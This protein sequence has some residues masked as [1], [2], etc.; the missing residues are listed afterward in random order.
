MFLRILSRLLLGPIST[1]IG[2][3]NSSQTSPQP[4]SPTPKFLAQVDRIAKNLEQLACNTDISLKERLFETARLHF[5]LARTHQ[6]IHLRSQAEARALLTLKKLFLAEGVHEEGLKT[7]LQYSLQK[8]RPAI[9]KWF[10]ERAH[11]QCQGN[12]AL[13]LALAEWHFTCGQTAITQN[14]I[15]QLSLKSLSKSPRLARMWLLWNE[16]AA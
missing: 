1:W 7:L 9:A 14:L 13:I 3:S 11:L 8:K 2:S 5:L 15:N 12:D 16:E 6:K 4:A 10:V